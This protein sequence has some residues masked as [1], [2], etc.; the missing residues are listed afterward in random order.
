MSGGPAR[1]EPRR[2]AGVDPGM[3]R[4]GSPWRWPAAIGLT[5]GLL[6]AGVF[7]VP[8]SWLDAF[9]SPLDLQPDDGL[10]QPRPWLVL[11]PPPEVIAQDRRA[12]PPPP[13]PAPSEPPVADWW[14]RSWRVRVA[15]DLAA[16]LR[17]TPED[18]SRVV[19]DALGLPTNL[20]MLVRPDSLLAARLLIMRRED[21]FR[22]D[23]LK[24][25]LQ[26]MTRAAAYRDIQA[27]AADMFDDFL[28]QDIIVPD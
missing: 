5:I 9:F 26:A 16:S 22:F 8:Q 28:H 27:R 1:G 13:L 2:P 11:V 23:E 17:P 4:R 14:T 7:L 19:L 18:S 21:G 25:Y 15:D 24:P 3:R 10:K 12:P 6:L 20:A